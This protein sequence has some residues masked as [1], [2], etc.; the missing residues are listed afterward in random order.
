MKCP[1]AVC[2]LKSTN[3]KPEVL[4]PYVPG[5]SVN[6]VTDEGFI[7]VLK[8][9]ITALHMHFQD[10]WSVADPPN[11]LC[12]FLGC[13]YLPW[14]VGDLGTRAVSDLRMLEMKALQRHDVWREIT[15]ELGRTVWNQTNGLKSLFRKS[16][17]LPLFTFRLRL[18]EMS[19]DGQLHG[20][21]AL[22]MR[23]E[24]GRTAGLLH[25]P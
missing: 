23:Q 12:A 8:R 6:H 15:G 11:L 16:F 9:A 20:A 3:Q 22:Q 25:R 4:M 19:A 24:P 7:S 13:L 21:G 17:Y 1:C 10:R 2:S 14:R 18:Y 5:S